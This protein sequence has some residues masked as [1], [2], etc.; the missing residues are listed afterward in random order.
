MNICMFDHSS[1]HGHAHDGHAHNLIVFRLTA[2]ETQIWRQETV[3]LTPWVR[4]YELPFTIEVWCKGGVL[5]YE[6][7]ITCLHVCLCVCYFV[8]TYILSLFFML[9]ACQAADTDL[10]PFTW[11]YLAAAEAY[12]GSR[13]NHHDHHAP[14]AAQCSLLCCRRTMVD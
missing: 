13:G 6:K 11:G 5:N 3:S 9:F 14:S 12:L 1:F 4:V 8:H 10:D 2:C 7:Q